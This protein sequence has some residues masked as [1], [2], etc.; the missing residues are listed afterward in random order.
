MKFS[1]QSAYVSYG[2]GP[3]APEWK[4]IHKDVTADFVQG[5]F[6]NLKVDGDG[7]HFDTKADNMGS[8]STYRVF[9]SKLK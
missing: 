6:E 7:F 8:Y 1:I 9:V 2:G 5:F 3:A 4:T